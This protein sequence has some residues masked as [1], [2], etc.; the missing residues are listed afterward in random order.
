MKTCLST[1]ALFAA[2]SVSSHLHAQTL[3]L[4][5]PGA[6]APAAG[7][8]NPIFKFHRRKPDPTALPEGP[9]TQI[10][11]FFQ[12]LS[13]GSTHARA[14]LDT[15]LKGTRLAERT[16][17]VSVLSDKVTEAIRVY[18]KIIDT[19]H[20][21]TQKVGKRMLVATFLTWHELQ[22]IQWRFTFY[23]ASVDWAL[24]DLRVSDNVED[25]IE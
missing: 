21:D 2:L 11:L 18:G 3:S 1:L 22:P 23:Q 17:N 19:E 7:E 12:T 14:A 24:I 13:K 16:E 25:L 6:P 10:Q 4:D 5:V 9:K 8:V 20:Y 15:L